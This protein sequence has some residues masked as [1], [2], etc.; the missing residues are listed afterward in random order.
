VV[1]EV[2]VGRADHLAVRSW[3]AVESCRMPWIPSSTATVAAAN[4]IGRVARYDP[5]E[6]HR[7]NGSTRSAM[8]STTSNA[9]ALTRA[10]G[11]GERHS[12]EGRTDNG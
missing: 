5:A 2:E 9:R 1:G 3:A 7:A 10:A 8:F 4:A 6:G 12:E 11:Q